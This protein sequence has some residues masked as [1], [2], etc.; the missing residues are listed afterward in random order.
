MAY[1]IDQ[2]CDD[3]QQGGCLYE[4]TSGSQWTPDHL[5]ISERP[6]KEASAKADS[7]NLIFGSIVLIDGAIHLQ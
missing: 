5:W 6:Q 3:F 2:S 7:S 1:I 4:P